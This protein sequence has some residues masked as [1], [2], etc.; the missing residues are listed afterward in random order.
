VTPPLV[1]AL[2]AALPTALV[3]LP[4]YPTRPD[5][6]QLA[7]CAAYDSRTVGRADILAWHDVIGDVPFTDAAQAVKDHYRETVTEIMP[8]WTSGSGSVAM[9]RARLVNVE[10]IDLVRDVDPD[11]P[12][13]HRILQGRRARVHGRDAARA[14]PADPRPVRGPRDRRCPA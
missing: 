12:Q 1:T 2:Q 13:W 11:D 3:T 9:R 7:L 14:G 8:S 6:Y 10:D 5:P 4:P